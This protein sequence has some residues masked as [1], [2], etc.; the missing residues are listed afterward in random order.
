M[1]RFVD[2]GAVVAGFVG[3]GMAVTVTISF[4]LVIPIE[5]IVILL[6]FPSGLVIGYYANQRSD[7]R[8]GP[9]SRILRNGLFAGLVTGV[10]AGLLLLGV[11][12]IFFFA[13]SGYP[14]FNRIDPK[15]GVV[16]PPTCATGADCVYARYAARDTAGDMAADRVTDGSSF[17][18]VYWSWQLTSAGSILALTLAGGLGGALLYGASR[19]KAGAPAGGHR[20]AQAAAGGSPG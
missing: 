7:R 12:S 18:P 3:V 16:I 19:P 14:D 1:T 2:R 17:A 10:A 11:K 9:W 4:L 20:E 13:D 8:H 15:T 5:P 6:A